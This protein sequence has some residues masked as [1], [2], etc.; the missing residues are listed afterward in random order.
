MTEISL[1]DLSLVELKALAYEKI[2]LLKQIQF[3]LNAIE[4][5]IIDLQKQATA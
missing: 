2:C 5:Q 1:Y 4:K 3:E